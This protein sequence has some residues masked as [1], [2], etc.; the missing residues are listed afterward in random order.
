MNR[1]SLI[2]SAQAHVVS[3]ATRPRS[4]AIGGLLI[5][6][7]VLA[8]YVQSFIQPANAQAAAYAFPLGSFYG[9]ANAL[10]CARYG[11][12]GATVAATCHASGTVAN[13][14]A[15]QSQNAGRAASGCRTYDALFRQYDWNVSVAEAI[16]QAES[17][18]N[19]SAISR[20]NDYG[21]MQL[22][23]LAIFDPAQNIAIAYIKY[24]TQGWRAWTAYN[25]GAYSRFL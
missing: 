8:L 5:G 16:C 17:G 10:Y 6:L 7:V 2:Q 1:P 21:L 20:T 22:H 19:P 18:G 9:D 4:L 14:A 24:Q 12:R 3:I 25:T 23:N 15:A 11:T 13:F